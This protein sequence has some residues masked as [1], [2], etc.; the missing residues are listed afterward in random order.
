[1]FVVPNS[2]FLIFLMFKM[3]RMWHQI[4]HPSHS[5]FNQQRITSPIFPTYFSLVVISTVLGFTRCIVSMTVDLTKLSGND[6]NKVKSYNIFKI[7]IVFDI[8]IFSYLILLHI[9]I[10][11]CKILIHS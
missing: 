5:S 2:I 1:M 4:I 11:Y 7:L 10:V 9:C 3:K 8:V 6:A